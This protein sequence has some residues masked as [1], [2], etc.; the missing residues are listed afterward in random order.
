MESVNRW[1]SYQQQQ[2]KS[3]K[4]IE[5]WTGFSKFLSEEFNLEFSDKMKRL[6]IEIDVD[7]NLKVETLNKTSI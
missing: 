2:N 1:S 7:N 6:F 3:K 5:S 4:K